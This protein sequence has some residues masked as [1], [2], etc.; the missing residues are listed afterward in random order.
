MPRLLFL[1]PELPYPPHSGGKLKS[2]K[3]LD[4]LAARHEVTLASPLKLDDAQ[5]RAAFEARSPCVRHLHRA[6]SVPRSAGSLLRSY[7]AGRPLNVERS[8]DAGLAAQLREQFAEQDLIFVDHYEVASYLPPRLDATVVYHA[9]NAYHMLWKRYAQLP[10]NPLLRLAALA[11]SARVRRAELAIARRADLV[12][13]AP[14][15]AQLL[16]DAGVAADR[17]THTYHLGDERQ[18]ARPELDF[19]RTHKR[20]MYVGLLGW[21]ANVQ[22]L[23]WF[24]EAVW[25]RLLAAHPDLSFHIVGRDPDARLLQASAPHPGIRLRGFVADLEQEY[26]E[27]RVSVAPLL[28]GSGMKVKVLDAMAR[29]LPTVTTAVGAEGID[30]QQRRQLA[31]AD[32]P[33]DMA[34]EIGALLQDRQRWDRQRRESRRLI[35]ERYTWERLFRGMHAAMD[36]AVARRRDRQRAGLAAAAGHA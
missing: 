32:A 13:A 12:L 4:A 36:G 7:L 25:P 10:A 24:I 6:V 2:L 21:E 1:T 18:L 8:F 23:L 35:R 30:Y 29:G 15:D 16:I 34:A 5:H 11:E 3:L 20:L 14:N 33:A 22:G 9:H 27:A 19:D 17:I 26:R 31:V 28:F